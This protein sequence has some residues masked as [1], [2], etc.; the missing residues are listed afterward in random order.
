MIKM[1][2]MSELK[3]YRADIDSIDEQIICLFEKRMK[4]SEAVAD[5]KLRTG[6]EVLDSAREA[7]KIDSAARQAHDSFNAQGIRELFSQIMAISR[8]KQYQIL[9]AHGIGTGDGFDLI[10][11]LALRGANVVFQ[12]VQGAYSYGAMKE[13]FGDSI[14]SIHV[15]TW[16]EAAFQV[17]SHQ[18]D[19][20]VLPIEN[21]TAGSVG[22]IYDL[23]MKYEPLY[24]VGE[25]FLRVDHVLLGCKGASKDTVR[26]VFSHPQALAQCR[27]Y[28]LAHPQMKAEEMENTAVA[29]KYVSRTSDP[30]LA[31]IASREAGRLFELEVLDE[32][33]CTEEKNVTRFI[34]VSAFPV[35]TLSARNV[36]ICFETPHAAGSLYRMLSHIIYNGL[37]MT[38]I[39]S[40][41][42]PGKQWQY[43]FFVDFEGNLKDTAVI[44]A[45][46]GIEAEADFM[47][48]LGNY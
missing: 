47:R 38:R 18:A 17:A 45:L 8:K 13:F 43:R 2:E 31:A 26:R 19:Y 9:A 30:S 24:I 6:M 39:E 29:A 16:D 14:T 5:Y 36:S 33:I 32:N 28:L 44:S 48:I 27:Q 37:N 34:I 1:S 23:L 15:D 42:V 46:K 21:S 7:K 3:D 4:I 20:A 35:H 22:S 41:P 10:D 40:R 11:S 25:Q 12:G